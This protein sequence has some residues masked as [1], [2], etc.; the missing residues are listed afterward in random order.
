MYEKKREEAVEGCGNRVSLSIQ[1]GNS[2]ARE[3]EANEL[4]LYVMVR[5]RGQR[6]RASDLHATDLKVSEV[7]CL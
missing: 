4:Y 3:K 2:R 5:K 1:E 7:P 6:K